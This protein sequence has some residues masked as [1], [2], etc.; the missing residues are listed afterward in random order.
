MS[1]IAAPLE[2]MR[3]WPVGTHGGTY[4]ANPVV[5]AAAAAT[6]AV[7][8]DDGLLANA[9]ERGQ[10]LRDGLEEMQGRWPFLADVRGPGL[11]IGLEIGVPGRGPD[12]DLAARIQRGCLDHNLL[13][14]TCGTHANV[15]RWIPPLVVT[16]E[17]IN[18]GLTILEE[19]LDEILET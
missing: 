17:Q 7:I 6:I 12:K 1:A 16:E 5:A 15:I 9:V 18:A 3:R 10:Q 4:G 14:L 8:R 11:M 2:L 19:T 13:L